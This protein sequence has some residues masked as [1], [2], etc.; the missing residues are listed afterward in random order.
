[1][2]SAVHQTTQKRHLIFHLKSSLFPYWL[3]LSYVNN[4]SFLILTA[5]LCD[6]AHLIFYRMEQPCI[7][8]M[9]AIDRSIFDGVNRLQPTTLGPLQMTLHISF[10]NHWECAQFVA[11]CRC[12]I[13]NRES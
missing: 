4:R 13:S 8:L 9:I 1:M 11:S 2:L 12:S 3:R 7:S 10:S 6:T 5:T